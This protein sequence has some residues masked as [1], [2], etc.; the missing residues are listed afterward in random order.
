MS[1]QGK[2]FPPLDSATTSENI[3]HVT[4]YLV[5]EV[6][7]RGDVCFVGQRHGGGTGFLSW[8]P[9][10]A[11]VHIKAGTSAYPLGFPTVTA[12]QPPDT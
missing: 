6:I 10:K 4:I 5:S 11:F 8:K 2:Y 1:W 3:I 7:G 9:G 12:R